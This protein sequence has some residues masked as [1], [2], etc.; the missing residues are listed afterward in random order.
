MTRSVSGHRP[1]ASLWSWRPARSLASGRIYSLHRREPAPGNRAVRFPAAIGSGPRHRYW[2][3]RSRRAETSPR[4]V[5]GA[6][7]VFY[8]G[9]RGRLREQGEPPCWAF[10]P[11]RLLPMRHRWA[12][13]LARAGSSRRTYCFRCPLRAAHQPDGGRCPR[14][15]KAPPSSEPARL[16]GEAG[17]RGDRPGTRAAA[18]AGA[19][20]ACSASSRPAAPG[21]PGGRGPA[22]VLGDHT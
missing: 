3:L 14:R 17:V 12:A 11:C 13:A 1:Q 10:E 22:R 19:L 6:A 2:W 20:A 9:R 4:L 15:G 7:R 16:T 5:G 8:G 21:S 18:A